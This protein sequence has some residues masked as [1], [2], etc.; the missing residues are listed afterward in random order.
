[1]KKAL[2]LGFCLVLAMGVGCAITDY[3]LIVDN[4]QVSNGQGTGVVNTNGKALIMSG[5]IATIWS[6]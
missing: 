1:M 3:E 5:G 2:Y 4:D 6:D